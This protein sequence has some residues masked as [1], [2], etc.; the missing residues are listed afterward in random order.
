MLPGFKRKLLPKFEDK[1]SG[2][3]PIK[4]EGSVI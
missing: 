3:V 4:E 2:S 1:Q